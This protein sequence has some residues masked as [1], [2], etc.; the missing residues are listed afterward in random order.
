MEMARAIHVGYIRW[1][2]PSQAEG[3]SERRQRESILKDTAVLGVEI[4]LWLQDEGL[5]ASTGANLKRGQLGRFLED[6]GNGKVP[7]GSVLYL[8]EPSRLTRMGPSKAMRILANLEDSGVSLRLSARQQTLHGESLCEVLHFIVES[9]SGHTFTQELGRKLREVWA[10][11]RE[12]SRRAPGE[13]VLT[14]NTPYGIRATGGRY[15]V[16][17]GWV[18]RRY[19]CDPEE[20]RIATQIYEMARDGYSPRAIARHLNDAGVPSP[21]ASRGRKVRHGT[22]VW[23]AEV[24][25]KLL[26]N[27][28]YLD[29]SY[30]PCRMTGEN[31]RMPDGGVIPGCFPV[32]LP[33]GLWEAANAEI[34]K[35]SKDSGSSHRSGVSNL[36]TGILKCDSCGG[37]VSLR[38]GGGTGRIAALYCTNA[39]DGACEDHGYIH[40]SRFEAAALSRL[41]SLLDPEAILSDLKRAHDVVD[42]SAVLER[43]RVEVREK[44]R[45]VDVL[46]DRVL[47]LA[48]SSNADLYEARLTK[49]RE[50]LRELQD[51]LSRTEEEVGRAETVV[52][53]RVQ[54]ARDMR[55]LIDMAV[56]GVPRGELVG[57]VDDIEAALK[58]AELLRKELGSDVEPA[59]IKLKAALRRI[60]KKVTL[61]LADETFIL[62]LETGKEIA[63]KVGEPLRLDGEDDVVLTAYGEV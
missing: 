19:E 59:R 16:G 21:A 51:R 4:D 5:S 2:D 22:L 42:R 53:Q 56:Y 7:P 3:D 1:S 18:G 6:V 26:K 31:R 13:K 8:D 24:V 17:K 9:A 27:R 36:F 29:G 14:G 45:A 52:L 58:E 47:S 46:V 63:G 62:T 54:A 20:A 55:G 10:A 60:I 32:F 43:L 39:R 23:R 35:H 28:V 50:E 33:A 25:R 41:A 37:A 61:K 40:R 57:R 44:R 49:A 38:S 34:G 15:S 11:K 12:E 48:D 30:Q